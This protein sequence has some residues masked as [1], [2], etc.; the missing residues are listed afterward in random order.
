MVAN[1]A[2]HEP[3]PVPARPV[4]PGQAPEAI[5][6]QILP[7]IIPIIRGESEARLQKAGPQRRLLEQVR[8]DI[9]QGYGHRRHHRRTPWIGRSIRARRGMP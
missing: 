3:F 7:E 4:K 5:Q 9:S 2:V 6:C 8:S 1:D